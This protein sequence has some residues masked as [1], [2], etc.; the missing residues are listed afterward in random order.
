LLQVHCAK[1]HN[2]EYE[3]PFQLVTTKSRADHTPE[4]LRANLDATLRLVDP[5][6]PSHSELL[7]TTL[8][9][10][11][12]RLRPRPI[13]P[14]SND[15][16]YQIL[17]RWVQNLCPP[18]TGAEANRAERVQ[19]LTERAETFAIDRDQIGRDRPDQNAPALSGRAARPEL[20]A[21]MAA[22]TRIP[23]PSRFVRGGA[24]V[25][26]GSNPAV[27]DEF[28]LPFAITGVKPNLAPADPA[29]KPAATGPDGSPAKPASPAAPDP[30]GEPAKAKDGSGAPKKPSKPLTIDPKLLERALQNRNA[31]R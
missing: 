23:P 6:N 24:P 8:R 18:S 14:G 19:T 10:H 4:A 3:G 9:A 26:Q 15:P 1:C 25:A 2:G 7:S 11:G 27:P 30:S 17:A 31:G 12:P 21:G 28:P 29:S 20:A 5:K 13:F 16:T 22:E